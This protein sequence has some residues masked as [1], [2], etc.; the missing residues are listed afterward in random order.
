MVSQY[1]P[2]AM[3]W[4]HQTYAVSES[5]RRINEGETE[6]CITSPTGGG[7][8]TIALRLCEHAIANGLTAIV[9][10]NRRL[11]T[12]Q[13]LRSLSGSGIRV[14][15]RAADFESWTDLDAPVQIVSAQTEISRVLDARQKHGREA[16]LHRGDILLADEAHLQ[17]GDKTVEMF[18]EYEQKYGTIRIGLTATPVGIGKIYKNGLI[19]A[20]NNSQLRACGALVWATRFEPRVLDL[21]KIR[22]SKTGVFSQSE[23]EDA[24]KAIWSQ[25]VVANIWGSWKLL[26]PD[27][28]PGLG[29]APGVK[30]SLG[31][32][33]EFWKHGVN[34]AHIEAGGI[35]VDGKFKST[36]EQK[37]RDELFAR[38]RDGSVPHT[39]NRYVLREGINLPELYFLQLATPI[40]D[41][42]G[43]IQIVGRVLR[44]HPSKTMARI[45]DHCGVIHMHGSPNMD[46]DAQWKQYFFEEDEDRI[47]KD[48]NEAMTNP[49]GKESSPITC[50]NPNCGAMRD[51]GPKCPACGT[52]SDRSIRNVIQESGELREVEGDVFEKRKVVEKP[53][54]AKLW[55]GI[56]YQ[57]KNAGKTFSQAVGYFKHVHHYEPPQN[58]PLMP[59]SPEDL[60]R[61]IAAVQY[62]DLFPY[63][64]S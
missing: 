47:T 28:R 40:A 24:A 5:V 2:H 60:R 53:E 55:V 30:E 15:C 42:K 27:A 32:A 61:K 51:S 21:D 26:N 6:F 35:F 31:L 4:D 44:A 37:D 52:E 22:K 16:E 3:D 12:D 45:C 56:Y 7:K 58:L 36:T 64:K 41:L 48:R 34:C 29:M 39:W 17:R 8:A 10:S 57:F 9:M 1:V 13:L 14:G 11:L 38:I 19:V 63:K 18:R 25:H 46:R 50:P 23:G 59:K 43:Y 33:Q 49:E 54:T 62:D 20:G